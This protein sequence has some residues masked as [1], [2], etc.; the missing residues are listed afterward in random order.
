MRL[1]FYGALALTTANAALAGTPERDKAWDQLI[2]EAQ[3]HGGEATQYK[4]STSYVFKN[5]DGVVYTF[6]K[7]TD[8]PT[9]AVCVMAQDQ[10][11][12]VCGNWDTGKMKYGRRA[13]DASSWTYSDSPP[14]EKAPEGKSP[15]ASLFS[16][17]TDMLGGASSSFGG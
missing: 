5:K 7:M 3:K 9:R 4:N 15:F 1:L 2:A 12:I 11:S 16:T 6:T 14:K 10:T 17:L 8:N 13:D